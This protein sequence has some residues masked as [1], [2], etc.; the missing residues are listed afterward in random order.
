MTNTKTEHEN[1]FD[2]DE[3]LI[4]VEDLDALEELDVVRRP[5]PRP[6]GLVPP[7]F[8]DE[9]TVEQKLAPIIPIRPVLPPRPR[10]YSPAP[11]FDDD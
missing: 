8:D 11:S 2:E 10:H 4:E 6:K 3:I 9:P 7:S 5:R 1:E